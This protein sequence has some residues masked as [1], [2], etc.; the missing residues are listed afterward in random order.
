MTVSAFCVLV[1]TLQLSGVAF[2]TL[3]L[4]R[5]RGLRSGTSEAKRRPAP[6]RGSKEKADGELS[7]LPTMSSATSRRRAYYA[8]AILLGLVVLASF[9]SAHRRISSLRGISPTQLLSSAPP[10]TSYANALERA[11]LSSNLSYAAPW[12]PFP[13]SRCEFGTPQH[14]APCVAERLEGVVYAEELLYPDFQ[15]RQASQSSRSSLH[16]D[17][18]VESR[19]PHFARDEHR[20]RWGDSRRY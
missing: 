13:L 6:R 14:F 19:Q 7:W 18:Q 16:A 2:S 5:R 15:I 17:L 4:L 9:A 8:L 10:L 1:F 11:T 20:E 12:A 3:G